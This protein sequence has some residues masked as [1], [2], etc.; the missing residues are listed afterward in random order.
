MREER[1]QEVRTAFHEKFQPA[2]DTEWLATYHAAVERVQTTSEDT[3]RTREFQ[4]GLWEIEGVA[5]IG[6]GP[7]PEKWSTLNYVF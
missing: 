7:P 1:A 5:G 4:C 2:K 3:F 6:P